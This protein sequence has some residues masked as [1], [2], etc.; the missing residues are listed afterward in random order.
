MVQTAF[1]IDIGLQ[2]KLVIGRFDPATRQSPD[3]SLDSLNAYKNGVSRRHAALL[4]R[5]D[6]LYIVDLGSSNGTSV[7]GLRLFA[8]QPRSLRDGDAIEI[9]GVRLHLR[10]D[11]ARKSP[12]AFIA[13][14]TD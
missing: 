10:L 5:N 13:I 3:I 7:N 1:S 11:P 14:V 12:P 9:G 2:P 4:W 8:H 6:T